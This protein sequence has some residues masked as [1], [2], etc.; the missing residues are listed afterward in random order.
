MGHNRVSQFGKASALNV[1]R[2]EG[3]DMP[4]SIGASKSGMPSGG[5]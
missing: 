4:G 2:F 3:S 5:E 1:V